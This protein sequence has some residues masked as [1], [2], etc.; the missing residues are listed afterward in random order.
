MQ[1]F[2]DFYTKL[3]L[4]SSITANLINCS[5]NATIMSQ[6]WHPSTFMPIIVVIGPLDV[7]IFSAQWRYPSQKQNMEKNGFKVL[8]SIIFSQKATTWEE[9]LFSGQFIALFVQFTLDQSINSVFLAGTVTY[10]CPANCH[11]V[12][13]LSKIWRFHRHFHECSRQMLVEHRLNNDL[14][15]HTTCVTFRFCQGHLGQRISKCVR[16]ICCKL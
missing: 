15:T 7:Q 2:I 12:F 13:I 6:L 3:P 5:K 8:I 11:L 16:K 4:W 1:N 10:N 14:Y 9:K